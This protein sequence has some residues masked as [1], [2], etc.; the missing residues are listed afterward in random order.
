MS[1]R[2]S[3]IILRS[4]RCIATMKILKNC[5]MKKIFFS[6]KNN[7]TSPYYLPVSPAVTRLTVYRRLQV[8]ILWQLVGLPDLDRPI[9]KIGE[10]FLKKLKFYDISNCFLDFVQLFMGIVDVHTQGFAP[11]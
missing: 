6:M 4:S 8:R 9:H 3:G 10:V 1:L 2:S 11:L 7:V 5:E